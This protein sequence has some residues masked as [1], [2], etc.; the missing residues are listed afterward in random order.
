MRINTVVCIMNNNWCII[1]ID[2][3]G[4]KPTDTLSGGGSG[5]T[6]FLSFGSI[7]GSLSLNINGGNVYIYML[8]LLL[9]L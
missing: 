5:G 1:V 6:I 7:S 2:S 3:S 8:L 4:T 9:L